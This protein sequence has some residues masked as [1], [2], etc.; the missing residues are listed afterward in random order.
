MINY[1][2][3]IGGRALKIGARKLCEVYEKDDFLRSAGS[4]DFHNIMAT[5]K[6]GVSSETFGPDQIVAGECLLLLFLTLSRII[7]SLEPANL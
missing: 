5:R 3:R 7:T 1:Y 2:V 4:G 6:S